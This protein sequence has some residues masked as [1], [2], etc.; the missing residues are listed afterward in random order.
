MDVRNI[1]VEHGQTSTKKQEITRIYHI[2]KAVKLSRLWPFVITTTCVIL[3]IAY[4]TLT[5]RRFLFCV[6]VC[7]VVEEGKKNK[8]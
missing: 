3:L 7:G 6:C 4:K 2:V 1:I 8:Q 5:I